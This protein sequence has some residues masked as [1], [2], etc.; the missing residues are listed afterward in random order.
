MS[1]LFA[2]PW[3]DPNWFIYPMLHALLGQIHVILHGNPF[4]SKPA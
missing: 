1:D 2:P 4:K 3:V